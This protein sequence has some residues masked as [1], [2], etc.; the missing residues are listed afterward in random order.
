[1]KLKDFG[2]ASLQKKQRYGKNKAIDFQEKYYPQSMKGRMDRIR[3]I[4]DGFCNC[5]KFNAHLLK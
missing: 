3:R 2:K 5:S 1:M 4:I